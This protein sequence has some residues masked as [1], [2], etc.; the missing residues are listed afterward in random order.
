MDRWRDGRTDQWMDRQTDRWRDGRTDG[1]M[2]GRMDGRTE[3]RKDGR[4]DGWMDRNTGSQTDKHLDGRKDRQR[5]EGLAENIQTGKPTYKQTHIGS[6]TDNHTTNL[7]LM[8]L[9]ITS[10]PFLQFFESIFEA[11]PRTCFQFH[12]TFLLRH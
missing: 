1:L 8:K 9:M 2:D 10:Q 11:Q 5:T 4:T 7:I 3:G 12:K 6:R